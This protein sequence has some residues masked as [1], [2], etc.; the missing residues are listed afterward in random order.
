MCITTNLL[1]QIGTCSF[2]VSAVTLAIA[3]SMLSIV[4]A[5]AVLNKSSAD[6]VGSVFNTV[7]S[8]HNEHEEKNHLG[9]SV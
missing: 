7:K 3:W 1:K 6:K 9:A 4:E 2:A 5:V 8:K